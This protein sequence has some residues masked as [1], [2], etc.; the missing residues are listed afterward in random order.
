MKKKGVLIIG[1]LLLLLIVGVGLRDFLPSKTQPSPA[2]RPADKTH[3]LALEKL[4]IKTAGFYKEYT[5]KPSTFDPDQLA[6]Y[7]EV[8]RK[9]GYDLSSYL[10]QNLTF[11]GYRTDVVYQFTRGM[12][13]E[14]VREEPL[15]AWV[16]SSDSEIIC[17]YLSVREDSTL[18]PGIFSV[19]DPFLRFP[20]KE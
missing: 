9:G 4:G 14:V 3:F 15:N 17:V 8:C 20:S 11:T 5:A 16:V 1:L 18:A 2:V 6:L 12:E 10:G 7:P 13:N 19:N